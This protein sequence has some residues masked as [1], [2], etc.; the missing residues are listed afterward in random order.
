MARAEIVMVVFTR[1]VSIRLQATE[2]MADS[3]GST[4][5]LHWGIIY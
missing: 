1:V 2:L 5:A 3:V 4:G